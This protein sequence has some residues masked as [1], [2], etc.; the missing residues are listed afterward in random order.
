MRQNICW[1]N[2]LRW[3]NSLCW[4]NSLRRS[5]LIWYIVSKSWTPR[6]A[7]FPPPRKKCLLTRSVPSDSWYKILFSLSKKLME[8][9]V[10]NSEL[11]RQKLTTITKRGNT[12]LVNQVR[13]LSL[14][15]N[16]WVSV[17]NYA[18]IKRSEPACHDLCV[19]NVKL[20]I[21]DSYSSSN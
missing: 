9:N 6:R 11:L 18:C 2:S 5:N 4:S 15:N 16:Y 21:P 7:H 14:F 1:S 19:V 13:L 3:S 12:I 10:K 8:A 17:T 20:V